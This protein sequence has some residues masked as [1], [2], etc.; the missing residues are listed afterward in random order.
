MISKQESQSFA[1]VEIVFDDANAN[2]DGALDNQE[3]SG[4]QSSK[5][6]K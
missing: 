3:F 5:D 6:A 2:K 4:I 1:A